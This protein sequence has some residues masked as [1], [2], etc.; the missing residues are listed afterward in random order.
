MKVSIS[1][2]E[3]FKTVAR[4]LDPRRVDLTLGKNY[5][6]EKWDEVY[7]HLPNGIYEIYEPSKT[8]LQV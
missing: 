4:F 1:L 3:R 5:C 2:E 7:E 8:R 6:Q